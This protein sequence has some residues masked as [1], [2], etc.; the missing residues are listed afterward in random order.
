MNIMVLEVLLIIAI[1]L[2]LI[3]AI[4]AIRLTRA[5]KYSIAWIF[6][7]IAL[8]ALAFMRFGQF[9]QMIA[10]KEL[11][12]PPDFFVWLGIVSSFC[13]AVGV[14][15]VDKIFKHIR[16]IETQ[17]K[18]T[19]KRILNTILRTE[20]RER[21]H[22]SKE[23]HDGLGPLL[24]SAKMSISTLG[25]NGGDDKEL[26]A[27][28]SYVID[29]SIRSLREISNNLSP[30]TLKDFGL[31]RAVTNYI[32]KSQAI[33][34]IAIYFDSNLGDQ[35]FDT[36]VEII[37]F[38]VVCELIANSFKHSGATRIK[39]SINENSQ[40]VTIDY[41]DNGRGFDPQA[42]ID[43]GMGLSNISSRIA[44]LKGTV[45]ISASLGQGMSASVVVDLN[46]ATRWK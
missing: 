44:S 15:Y 40:V 46:Q 10:D 12:L 19:Q 32:N 45:D 41:S 39:L 17:Q 18:L 7:T 5:T 34:D 4:A 6:F 21:A 28:L 31:R 25:K 8:C 14:F 16:V 42:V 30:H 27:N 33:N 22:F 35:R 26:I 2:Q 20:E 9:F 43:M 13:F 1:I 37:L 38:R 23:L 3:A 36:N 11:R 24:A 29:E